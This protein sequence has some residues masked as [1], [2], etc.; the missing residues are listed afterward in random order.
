M[1]RRAAETVGINIIA[2]SGFYHDENA[3]LLWKSEEEIYRLLYR[4]C[5]EGMGNTGSLPGILKCAVDQKGFTPYVKKVLSATARVSVE[6]EMPIFCHTIPEL[7]QGSAL[8][9]F[10]AER[11]VQPHMVVVGHSGDTDD[12]DYLETLFKCGCYVGFDRFG[13]ETS[14]SATSVSRRAETLGQMCKR[15]WTGRILVS[16]DYAPYTGFFP[17]WDECKKSAHLEN[18]VDYTYFQNIVVPLLLEK[19]IT[20]QDIRTIT[21]ENPRR[22]FRKS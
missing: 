14:S 6:L 15:G 10:L 12:L 18:P 4:D 13:I 8:L 5:T 7:Q 17:D 20:G 16:H 3:V 9:D 1:I 2:S 21:V 11:G 19:G 22:F